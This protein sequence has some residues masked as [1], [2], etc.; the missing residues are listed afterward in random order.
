MR[1]LERLARAAY[2]GAFNQ[3]APEPVWDRLDDVTQ[4]TWIFHARCILKALAEPSDAMLKVGA[5]A[6]WHKGLSP[7]FSA[8]IN[9]IL[10]GEADE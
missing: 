9:H 3:N 10:E 7:A 1:E 4:N 5:E 8:M 2:E 6:A